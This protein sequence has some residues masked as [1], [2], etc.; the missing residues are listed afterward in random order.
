MILARHW[1]PTELRRKMVLQKSFQKGEHNFKPCFTNA[2]LG[3]EREGKR[4]EQSVKGKGGH[5]PAP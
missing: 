1:I 4:V 3:G 5:A 2:S